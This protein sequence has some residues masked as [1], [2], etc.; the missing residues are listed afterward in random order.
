MYYNLIHKQKDINQLWIKLEYDANFD[1]HLAANQFC[2]KVGD[3][4]LLDW[5]TTYL[6]DGRYKGIPEKD[7]ALQKT[8]YEETGVPD[9]KK[10]SSLTFSMFA[11]EHLDVSFLFIYDTALLVWWLIPVNF[12]DKAYIFIQVKNY[13]DFKLNPNRSNG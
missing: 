11:F 8:E 2:E 1:K 6:E 5:Y 9:C 7:F 10:I 3:V 4:V 13:I 12:W